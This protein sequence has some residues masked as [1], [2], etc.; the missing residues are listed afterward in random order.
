MPEPLASNVV[1]H[2][3]A[4]RADRVGQGHFSAAVDDEKRA[5]SVALLFGGCGPTRTGRAQ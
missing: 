3:A 4:G 5:A 2:D 1:A